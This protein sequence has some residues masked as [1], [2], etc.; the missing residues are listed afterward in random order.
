MALGLLR[1]CR[2]RVHRNHSLVDPGML[3]PPPPLVGGNDRFI[4]DMEEGVSASATTLTIPMYHQPS[5]PAYPSLSLA[6]PEP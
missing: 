6:R 5:T 2:S 1:M 4:P 3:I